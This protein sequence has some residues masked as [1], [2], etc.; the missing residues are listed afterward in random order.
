MAQMSDDSNLLVQFERDNI[1]D[2]Y[3]LFYSIKRKNLFSTIQ[4]F[5]ELWEFFCRLDEI[6]RREIGDM[7]VATDPNRTFP[8]IL[9][10]NSHA[11][12]R[13]SMELAFSNCMPEGRSI[14]RDAVETVAYAHHMLRDPANQLIWMKKDEPAEK[15]AFKKAFEDNKKSNLFAGL[16][17]LHEKY[18]QLSEAGSHPTMQSFANR[19]TIEDRNG[20]RQ[21]TVNYSGAPDRRLF[22]LEIFSRLLTCFVMERTFFD[23][24]KARFELD[25]RLV[26]MRHDFQIF[27]ENLRRTVITKY[28][29]Q[30]PPTKPSQP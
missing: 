24:F 25:A 27:K 5:P 30:P 11:K 13:I 3:R 15:K 22:A 9:Y 21:M 26:Q 12:M 8:V 4:D 20:N 2:D 23:D 1:K 17:E 10:I 28:N 29:V 14:L 6:W 18:G 7:E 19:L 16:Q